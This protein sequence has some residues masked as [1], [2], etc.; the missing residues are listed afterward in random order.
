VATFRGLPPY[1]FGG[2]RF[3]PS[4]GRLIRH[5]A[6]PAVARADPET[7][8]GARGDAILPPGSPGYR[9]HQTEGVTG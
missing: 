1:P 2:L 8:I 3:T 6:A 7:L 5:E 9:D 4:A